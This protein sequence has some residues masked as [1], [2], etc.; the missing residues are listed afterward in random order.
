MTNTTSSNSDAAVRVLRS[1]EADSPIAQRHLQLIKLI[2]WIRGDGITPAVSVRR[3]VA[4]LDV[5]DSQA[6]LRD[7]F[8]AYW[9]VLIETIDLTTL[10]AD[11][12]FSSHPAFLSEF[13]DR[14][15]QK[16]LPATPETSDACELFQLSVN[17]SSDAS[18]IIA[19][20][21]ST[22][23]RL[24]T[25]TH[26]PSSELSLSMW[27]HE[28]MDAITYC[29]SQVRA[30]GFSPE[31]RLRMNKPSVQTRPFHAIAADASA[32]CSAFIATPHDTQNAQV[33][34]Q[35]LRDRLE[36]CRQVTTEVTAH[37]EEHGISVSLVFRLREMRKRIVRIREL[38][39]CLLSES[40]LASSQKLLS[41][42]AVIS[43][44][45]RSIRA[46]MKD[47]SSLLAT[48]MSQR[49]AEVGEHYITR[50]TAAYKIMLGKAAGGGA[51]I[52]LT[53]LIKFMLLG[54]SLSIFWA[55]FV[56]GINYAVT[57]VVVQLLH[58]T[59]ATKQPAMTAP[60]M[61][62][63]LKDIETNTALDEF[64]D[65][66]TH[67]VRSQMAAV[68]GN[69]AL[70]IPCVVGISALMQLFGDTP[71]LKHKDA[72]YV[73]DSLTLWG[74]T[75]LFAA[76][77]GVLLFASSMI[78]GWTENW[79]VLHRL[80]S[81]IRYNPRITYWLGS[82]RAMRWSYFWRKNI[83]G[84]ASNVSLGLMLGLMPA[85][86]SF[87]GLGLEVRHITLSAGQVAAA[88]ASLGLEVLRTPAFWWCFM[89][90]PITGFLNIAVSFYFAFRVA[91]SAHNVGHV[92]RARIRSAIW[93]RFKTRPLDYFLP[94]RN[95]HV[96]SAP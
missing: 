29:A 58:F 47:N 62:A 70:V 54:A 57:F 25:L 16:I 40:P 85:F 17:N 55:G 10:L 52:S 49:S 76:L 46:L 67:L 95:S 90:L 20:D 19:L 74:P 73:L 18:W 21:A 32:F 92:D 82:R 56:A 27:Q 23:A 2:D 50:D 83:S 80:S 68:I 44:D 88:A 11:F 12:G 69:L 86:A 78:A 22:L 38:M 1:L 4:L 35:H 37:L 64:I 15:N 94:A 3:V 39:D 5:L 36:L 72:I 61:A 31:V 8:K 77:T 53:T 13:I 84:F 96:P 6:D 14:I 66:V 45:Q 33:S 9:A 51:I 60:A 81:A 34:A 24:H 48:K 75:A 87:F 26:L 42:L 63:K 41:R 30:I 59:V 28:L 71:I 89:A 79:F 65:E 7:R 43:V 93:E 91:L